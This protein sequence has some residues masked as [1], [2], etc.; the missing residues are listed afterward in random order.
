MSTEAWSSTTLALALILLTAYYAWQTR[1]TVNEMRLARGASILPALTLS[2]Y[3]PG[4]GFTFIVLSNHGP[5]PAL[6]IDV[7]FAYGENGP[8]VR[9]M[10]PLLAQGQD[11]RFL[12]PNN[13]HQM[14]ELIEKHGFI[15]L[16]GHCLDAIGKR[17]EVSRQIDLSEYWILRKASVNVLQTNYEKKIAEEVEKIRGTLTSLTNEVA[18]FLDSAS[19]NKRHRN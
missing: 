12:E 1:Q 3:H 11:E 9:W 6:D 16:S 14:D 4:A 17:H 13:A 8:R 2:F 19:V 5:G 15:H 18:N 7:T 10:S